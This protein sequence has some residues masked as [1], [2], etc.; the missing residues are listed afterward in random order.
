MNRRPIVR[1]D[2]TMGRGYYIVDD[3]NHNEYLYHDGE[4]R[5]GAFK[6]NGDAF[7]PS[8]EAA[9]DFLSNRS[10]KWEEK[11]KTLSFTGY[12]LSWKHHADQWCVSK[13]LSSD[14][15]DYHN[16]HTPEEAVNAAYKAI[17]GG[18]KT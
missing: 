10:A 7:W 5:I 12:F 6:E 15:D 16:G 17:I 14:P 4:W 9:E 3:N 8:L 1:P 13:P 11:L 2:P 18:D